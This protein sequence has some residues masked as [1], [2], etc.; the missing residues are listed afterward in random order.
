M[1]DL[2]YWPTANGIKVPILLHELGIEYRAHLVNIRAGE[3]RLSDFLKLNPNGRIPVIVDTEPAAG[4]DP[5]GIHESAAILIYLAEKHGRFLPRDPM[6]RYQILQWLFWHVGHAASSFGL[7][8]TLHEK[9]A[10]TIPSSVD[11]L[12]TN[13]VARLY[14]VLDEQLAKS[15]YVAGPYSIADMAIFPWIQAARQGQ[16]LERFPHIARWHADVG[17][18]P[19]VRKAYLDGHAIASA[20]RSLAIVNPALV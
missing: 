7:Y 15:D 20:E 16:D 14:R 19:A 5:I 9:I 1:I 13:E 2:Y 8:Q 18:R 6:G 17:R 11:A 4:D 10:D 12:A 3:N